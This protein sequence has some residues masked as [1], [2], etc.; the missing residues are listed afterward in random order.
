MLRFCLLAALLFPA[1]VAGCATLSDEGSSARIAFVTTPRNVVIQMLRLANVTRDDVVYDLGSGD[2]RIVI[3]AARQF[4]SQAVGV[5]IDPDLIK[6]SEENTRSAGVEGR[7]RFIEKDLFRV[8]LHDAT[9]VTLFLLPGPNQMLIQKFMKELRPGTRIVSHMFDMGEWQ[10]DKTIKIGAS[11]VYYW[12]L[13]ADAG[14][15]WRVDVPD[16]KGLGPMTLSFRQ[17]FQKLSGS[18]RLNSAR[19]DLRE[20][21]IEGE[22]LFLV[23]SGNIDGQRV[24]MTF[25]GIV[26][27]DTVAGTVDV[28]GGLNAGTYQWTAQRT[29]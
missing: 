17:A 5:E 12:V 25:S 10:P 1:F 2:G 19:L 28:K 29:R 24:E 22:K 15:T 27:N 11:I 7:V 23:T 4:G 18:V 21:R 26:R 9:V 3:A 14:G 13:P 8:D 20:A 6:Q 16:T